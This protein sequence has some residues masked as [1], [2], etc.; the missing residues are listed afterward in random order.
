MQSTRVTW[1]CWRAELLHGFTLRDVLRCFTPF[2]VEDLHTH[3]PNFSY[4][5]LL[6]IPSILPISRL[7]VCRRP[8]NVGVTVRRLV[9]LLVR[10]RRLLLLVAKMICQSG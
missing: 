5:Y 7:Q 10:M 1:S 8:G 6:A 3:T 2:A 9:L 4:T